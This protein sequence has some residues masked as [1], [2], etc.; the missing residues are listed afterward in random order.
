ME[1]LSA[2]RAQVSKLQSQDRGS[3][4]AVVPREARGEGSRAHVA[5]AASQCYEDGASLCLVSTQ[6]STWDLLSV[7]QMPFWTLPQMCLPLLPA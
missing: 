4:R 5:G 1:H 3:C 2:Y 6:G 7:P